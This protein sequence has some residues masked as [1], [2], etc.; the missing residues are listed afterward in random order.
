M[1]DPPFDNLPSDRG[2]RPRGARNGGKY[3]QGSILEGG[4][5]V[6]GGER[7]RVGNGGNAGPPNKSQKQGA[8]LLPPDVYKGKKKKVAG[9]DF[10]HRIVVLKGTEPLL[11]G[12]IKKTQGES[13][14]LGPR[15][16]V[17]L[18]DP[19]RKRREITIKRKKDLPRGSNPQK[20]NLTRSQRAR[21]GELDAINMA[22]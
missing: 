2:K 20:S 6:K 13:Q 5:R 7:T 15:R 12:G 8:F 9:G 17:P 14:L 4:G 3:T 1:G 22:L 16:L 21:G 11:F 18:Q 10:L 19:F